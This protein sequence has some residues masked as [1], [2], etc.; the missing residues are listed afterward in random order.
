[1]RHQVARNVGGEGIV[2]RVTGHLFDLHAAP[3]QPG[4]NGGQPVTHQLEHQLGTDALPRAAPAQ[5]VG[6]DDVRVA[7]QV[8]ATRRLPPGIEQFRRGILEQIQLHA[9][10]SQGNVCQGNEEG[11]MAYTKSDS[12]IYLLDGQASVTPS[13][14]AFKTLA[15]AFP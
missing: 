6:G 11:R 13:P 4:A 14:H 2:E 3:V 5:Q 7:Q 1:M 8:P 15:F 12:F 9:E 10:K